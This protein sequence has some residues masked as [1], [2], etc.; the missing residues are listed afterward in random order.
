MSWWRACLCRKQVRK[1]VGSTHEQGEARIIGTGSGQV[2]PLPAPRQDRF[3]DQER[4]MK[5][6]T[7][8]V[9]RLAL[10]WLWTV[11]L[12]SGMAHALAPTAAGAVDPTLGVKGVSIVNP[13]PRL[14][15]MAFGA[16]QTD[17]KFVGAGNLSITAGVSGFGAFRVLDNGMPIH[18]SPSMVW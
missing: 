9:F 15:Q 13:T 4:I 18:R 3:T 1:C 12:S 17:G 6:G 10:A 7:P 16:V 8:H 5:S 14:D 2:S 11:A